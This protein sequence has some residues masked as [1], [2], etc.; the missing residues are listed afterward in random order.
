[1]RLSPLFVVLSGLLIAA[2]ARGG[3]VDVPLL[4]PED[5]GLHSEVAAGLNVQ[6]GNVDL[7]IGT[8]GL[9]V[10][11]R[12]NAHR[13]ISSSRIELGFS[14]GDEIMNNAVSHLRHELTLSDRLTWETY[15][16]GGRNPHRRLGRA[17]AGAGPRVAV[18]SED[19]FSLSLSASY[20]FELQRFSTGDFPDS[21]EVQRNHRAST[22]A[23]GSLDLDEGVALTHTTYYQ[24]RFDAPSD[25]RVL[26]LTGL[27]VGIVDDLG[28][29]V[30]FTL[31][32]Q[33]AP[34][35]T[36]QGLDTG[37]NVSLTYTL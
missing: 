19:T 28:L 1:M 26:T 20:L 34:P 12:R 9:L 5:E 25:Y 32:Y 7:L 4:P 21:G 22:Y 15:V 35:A 27:N 10:D 37:T 30:Q 36:I 6:T 2:P 16:Q 14:E 33:S 8:G 24:P 3:I 29:L 31:S 11:Y 17:I 13:V 23:T 18:V